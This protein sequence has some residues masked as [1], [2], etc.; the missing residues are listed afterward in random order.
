MANGSTAWRNNQNFQFSYEESLESLEFNKLF[1]KVIPL[2]IYDITALTLNSPGTS[3]QSI[4]I[5]PFTLVIK[6]EY[7]IT[8]PAVPVY[9]KVTTTQGEVIQITGT[10]AGNPFY[11][12]FT[13]KKKFLC[14]EL[15]G[16]GTWI[17]ATTN[18]LEWKFYTETQISMR[19]SEKLIILAKLITDDVAEEIL[20][21]DYSFQTKASLGKIDNVNNDLSIYPILDSNNDETNEINI[22]SGNAFINGKYVSISSQDITVNAK[23]GSQGRYDYIC[24]DDTGTAFLEEGSDFAVTPVGD[25]LPNYPSESLVIGKIEREPSD[26]DNIVLGTQITT[27]EYTKQNNVTN[28]IISDSTLGTTE[29][30]IPVKSG[31]SDDREVE[32]STKNIN[33]LSS[34]SSYVFATENSLNKTSADRIIL[35][36]ED[37]GALINTVITT[38]HANGGGKIT[39]L[40]GTYNVETI[41]D[42]S[43]SNNITIEGMGVSTI[44]KRNADIEELILLSTTGLKHTLKNF[45]IDGNK[46]VYN[47]GTKYGILE[48][49]STGTPRGNSYN[50]IYNKNNYTT[51][52]RYCNNLI[53]CNSFFNTD[54]GFY[55]CNNLTNCTAYSNTDNGFMSC[56]NLSSCYAYN[57][58]HGFSNSENISSCESLNNGSY[59]FFSC[60]QLTSSKADSN[61]SYGFESCERLS[62]CQS[63]SNT[64]GF[65]NCEHISSSYA[66]SNTS[67]GFDNCNYVSSSEAND[68][69]DSGFYLCENITGSISDNNSSYGYEQCDLITSS[70]ATNNINHCFYRCDNIGSCSATAVS[71]KNGYEDCD[72]VV[73]CNA[74]DG[75]Y[76]FNN[77]SLMQRNRS[78]TPTT[79]KYSSCFADGSGTY[80][81][82]STGTDTP[83]GGFNT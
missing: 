23:T 78:I 46:S 56:G 61:T 59:G 53:N 69:G 4:L 10:T 45:T 30:L 27:F 35:N 13:D 1:Q 73:N 63:K 67:Y 43:S 20:A 28:P 14:L 38:L 64:R 7:T 39:L 70:N 74:F 41:V 76:G 22:S 26:E 79:N 33:D 21:L 6:S 25:G 18:K 2:G 47:S 58:N 55:L 60:F 68:N 12:I 51:G 57:N 44:L 5:P 17:T 9:S 80:P 62:S 81:I 34:S 48:G 24:I 40:E 32:I 11:D 65:N 31:T 83:A 75:V 19:D 71:G 36:T 16:N 52:F 54:Y 72:M 49:T 77:C 50:N 8:L 66:N 3:N 42:L 29:N 82:A 37:A 15:N